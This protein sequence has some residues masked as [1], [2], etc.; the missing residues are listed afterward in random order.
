MCPGCSACDIGALAIEYR[1]AMMHSRLI[2]LFFIA[3]FSELATIIC[4]RGNVESRSALAARAGDLSARLDAVL[5]APPSL[6][7][8]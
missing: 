7:R 5:A 2:A 3:E 6:A 1:D 8:H 4:H